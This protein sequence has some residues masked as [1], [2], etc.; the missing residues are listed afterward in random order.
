MRTL[1]LMFLSLIVLFGC[2]SPQDRAQK[3][4]AEM[5]LAVEQYGPAC[6]QVGYVRDSDPWRTC[7]MQQASNNEARKGWFSRWTDWWHRDTPKMT[8]TSTTAGA[9][10]G[11]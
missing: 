1:I 7:V 10:M 5:S 9:A 2:A 6:T 11:K 8:E 4:Q 3:Q